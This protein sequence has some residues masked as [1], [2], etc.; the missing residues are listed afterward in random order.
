[1]RHDPPEIAPDSIRPLPGLFGFRIT[2]D[3]RTVI[4]A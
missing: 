4:P 2:L 3:N 1:M